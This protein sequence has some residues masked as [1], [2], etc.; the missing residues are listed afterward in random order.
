MPKP[1]APAPLVVLSDA[2]SASPPR[3]QESGVRKMP[4]VNLVSSRHETS[5]IRE[6]NHKPKTFVV[7]FYHGNYHR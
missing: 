1:T 5:E 7:F 3:P 4:R 6:G 2:D